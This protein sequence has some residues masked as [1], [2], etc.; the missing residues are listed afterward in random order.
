MD[1]T[2]T[3][4]LLRNVIDKTL[5]S[6]S[7]FEAFV[8]DHFPHVKRMYGSGM[9]RTAKV[10][11]LLEHI[12]CG[13]IYRNLCQL[14]PQAA[15][16][17]PSNGHAHNTVTN[18]VDSSAAH[19]CVESRRYFL[20]LTGT[21]DELDEPKIRALVAHIRKVSGDAELTLEV[22]KSGSIILHLRGSHEGMERLRAAFQAGELQDIMGHHLEGIGQND[23]EYLREIHDGVTTHIE[24]I[25]L[26][27]NSP[28]LPSPSSPLRA[29]YGKYVAMFAV[30]ALSFPLLFGRVWRNP[31]PVFLMAV[32]ESVSDIEPVTR[33]AP[34]WLI[35]KSPSLERTQDTMMKA[36][37]PPLLAS[38][39][40]PRASML[41]RQPSRVPNDH[42]FAISSN[43][44]EK[45]LEPMIMGCAREYLPALSLK[46]GTNIKLERVGTIGTLRV[47]DAPPSVLES[48]FNVCLLIQLSQVDLSMIPKVVTIK[49]IR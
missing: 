47:V 8:L 30:A 33:G 26:R 42:Q 44:G 11:L 19:A 48:G 29:R 45:S 23:V 2:L 7:A 15:S 22:I 49:V 16:Q 37:S 20:V 4:P 1:G 5:L 12:D 24:H 39:V 43:S 17:T 13:Q 35:P 41:S 3:L 25:D 34:V 6:D 32:P 38:Q 14:Y 21:I 10:N 40:A 36:K 18:K 31:S 9:D 27:S 46:K 28:A